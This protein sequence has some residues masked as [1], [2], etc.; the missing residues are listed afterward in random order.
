MVEEELV[1]AYFENN[2]FLVRKCPPSPLKSLRR[3]LDPLPAIAV[4]NPRVSEN[5]LNM[6]TRL[7]SAD[8]ERIRCALVGV[9]GWGNSAFTPAVL[10][11]DAQLEKFFRQ[12][13]E[14]SRI[15]AC[16]SDGAESLQA[17]MGDFLKLLIV[18][19]LPV[20]QERLN[21]VSSL[22]E[23]LGVN[24]VL[25]LRSILENLLRRSSPGAEAD[26]RSVLQAFRLIK[27]YGLTK[28]PQLE[29]FAPVE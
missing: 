17:G 24:G 4:M 14:E 27:A 5:D 21:K 10:S 6:N 9:L 29:I 13:L 22:L 8:L 15:A 28:D 26:G 18:P 3:K 19:A 16:F 25:T 7:F 1:E 23:R 2:G 12:E 20:A 11:S